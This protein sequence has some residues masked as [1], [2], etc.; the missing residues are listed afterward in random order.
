MEDIL[1]AMDADARI[2]NSDDFTWED[3]VI[4]AQRRIRQIKL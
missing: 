1:P 4:E 2:A 3:R